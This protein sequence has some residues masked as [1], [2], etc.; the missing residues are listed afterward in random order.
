MK[1]LI[2][3]IVLVTQQQLP[4]PQRSTRSRT[5]NRW[6]GVWKSFRWFPAIPRHLKYLLIVFVPTALLTAGLAPAGIVE[7]SWYA[8]TH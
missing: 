2:L 1:F 5:F 7:W 4:M 8:R 6:L 3:F